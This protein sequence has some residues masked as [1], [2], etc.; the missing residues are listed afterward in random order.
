MAKTYWD[1]R[2]GESLLLDDGRIKVGVME[3]SGQRARLSVEAD[4]SIS[5]EKG[6]AIPAI[7]TPGRL[8]IKTG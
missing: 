2:V 5:I 7:S 4:K 6:K 8:G 1:V 3:K